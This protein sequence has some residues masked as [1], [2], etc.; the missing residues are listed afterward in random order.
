MQQIQTALMDAM[1][2]AA[3]AA[4]KIQ[5]YAAESELSLVP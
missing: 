1:Q 3:M 2:T 5:S 4:L